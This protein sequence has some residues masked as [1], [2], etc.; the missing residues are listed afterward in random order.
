MLGQLLPRLSVAHAPVQQQAI[1]LAMAEL[2]PVVQVQHRQLRIARDPKPGARHRPALLAHLDRQLDE[3][4]FIHICHGRL[5]DFG[6]LMFESMLV[7]TVT[8][9]HQTGKQIQWPPTHAARVYKP[10]TIP[11]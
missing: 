2:R 4:D 6:V 11:I 3:V 9:P 8:H 10:K 7:S 5:D 1:D